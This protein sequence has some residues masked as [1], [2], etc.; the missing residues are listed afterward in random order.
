MKFYISLSVIIDALAVLQGVIF[1]FI[2]LSDNKRKLAN[3]LLA[4]FLLIY[5]TE[6]VGILFEDLDLLSEHPVLAFLPINFYYAVIPLLFLYTKSITHNFIWKRDY[7]HLIPGAVEFVVGVGLFLYV[8]KYGVIEKTEELTLFFALAMVYYLGVIFFT[9]YYSIKLF[10]YVQRFNKQAS[11]YYSNLNGKNLRWTYRLALLN[12]GMGVVMII[13]MFFPEEYMEE[14]DVI[15]SCVNLV[16][17]YWVSVGGLRQQP[18]EM[19]FNESE[20]FNT[21]KV[22]TEPSEL[23]LE[24]KRVVAHMN[25]EKPY[26]ECDLVLPKLAMLCGINQR[27]LSRAIKEHEGVNFNQFINKYRVEETKRLLKDASNQHLSIEGIG[28][29]AGFNSKATFYASFK[30]L[31]GVSPTIFRDQSE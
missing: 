8:L 23:E 7:K 13:L 30:K 5:S 17:V 2:L 3:L 25:K 11:D 1:A 12:L 28:E 4:V 20:I 19:K 21:S 6:F 26:V 29:L 10:I 24:Y 15:M 9:L 22:K 18:I 31:C 16:F 14:T 27:T